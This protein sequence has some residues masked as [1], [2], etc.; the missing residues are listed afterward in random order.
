M[1][2]V[3]SG[4]TYESVA[5]YSCNTGYIRR[6]DDMRTC[7]SSGDW[8]GSEPTC[9]SK[10][11]DAYIMIRFNVDCLLQLLT[12]VV[13]ATLKVGWCQYLRQPMIQWPLTPAILATL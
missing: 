5:T 4:T 2:S 8:S 13:W 7:E 3:S 1:V 6:G 11:N 12:V 10:N 9:S